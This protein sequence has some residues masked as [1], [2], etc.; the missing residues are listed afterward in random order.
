M[1]KSL[2]QSADRTGGGYGGPGLLGE[3]CKSQGSMTEQQCQMPG[4]QPPEE[5]G[6][7]V[8]TDSGLRLRLEVREGRGILN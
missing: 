5:E 3:V 8:S 7:P 2:T 4:P 1:S 6:T